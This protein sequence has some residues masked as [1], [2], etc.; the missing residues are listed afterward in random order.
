[1][2]DLGEMAQELKALS[3]RVAQGGL[4]DWMAANDYLRGT[5]KPR[6]RRRLPELVLLMTTEVMR[7][8]IQRSTMGDCSLRLDGIGKPLWHALAGFMVRPMTTTMKWQLATGYILRELD[9]GIRSHVPKKNR[10]PV[11][12]NMRPLTNERAKIYSTAI[13]VV[14]KDM[15][16][17]LYSASPAGGV[18]EAAAHDE[19]HR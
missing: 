19:P 13:L 6:N 10:P 4:P 1:M 5:P 9:H 14:I 11:V 2:T 7:E 16:Q 12:V 15:M 3:Q 18:Y 8:A 17:Q